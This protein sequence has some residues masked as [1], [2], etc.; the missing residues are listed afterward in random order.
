MRAGAITAASGRI[1][2]VSSGRA[3]TAASG[4]FAPVLSGRRW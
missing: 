3:A 1:A 2:P 4:H